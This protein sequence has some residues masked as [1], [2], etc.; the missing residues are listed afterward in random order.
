MVEMVE[1][2]RWPRGR[3]SWPRGRM[4]EMVECRMAERLNL[5]RPKAE[6]PRWLNVE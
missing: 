2:S 6:W 3:M 5:E 4:V 1:W